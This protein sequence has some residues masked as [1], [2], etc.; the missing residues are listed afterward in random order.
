MT[1]I[2][3]LNADFRDLLTAFAEEG[4][5]F[6]VVGAYA[7]AL[8]GVPRATGDLDVWVRPSEEN[9]PRVWRALR[10][11]GAPVESA[12]LVAADFA[13]PGMVYQIGLPPRR[14]DVLTEITGVTFDEGWATR[15]PVELAGRTVHF[16]GRDAFVRNKQATGRPKDLADVARL[17]R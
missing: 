7:L 9:A 15:I 11:F 4:V 12:G 16:I 8:H 6:L 1:A 14:I 2:D 5:E 3:D 10:R 13:A 17:K